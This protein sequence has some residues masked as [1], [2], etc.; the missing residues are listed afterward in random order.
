MA[1]STPNSYSPSSEIIVP[2]LSTSGGMEA[3][4]G[5]AILVTGISPS[6]RTVAVSVAAFWVY[7]LALLVG[8][9]ALGS[10][11]ALLVVLCVGQ[12]ASVPTSVAGI[13]EPIPL[14]V[15]GVGSCNVELSGCSVLFSP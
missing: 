1:M 3:V 10:R 11:V 9:G 4:G 12:E 5:I 6:V 8:S 2:T 14:L 15:Y 7:P 13:A